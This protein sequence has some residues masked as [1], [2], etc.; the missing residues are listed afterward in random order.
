MSCIAKPCKIVRESEK[1]ADPFAS[2]LGC[3]RGSQQLRI[4]HLRTRVLDVAVAPQ[5]SCSRARYRATPA[6]QAFTVLLTR[7]GES[8]SEGRAHSLR[9]PVISFHLPSAAGE[10]STRLCEIGTGTFLA[11]TSADGLFPLAWERPCPHYLDREAFARTRAWL[12]T[13]TDAAVLSK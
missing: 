1:L 11:S 12:L 5:K 7:V 3:L 4:Q 8:D 6:G 10:L 9:F 13:Q 2:V